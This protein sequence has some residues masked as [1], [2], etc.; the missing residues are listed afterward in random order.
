MTQTIDAPQYAALIDG[1]VQRVGGETRAVV[2]PYTRQQIG[3][4][5]IAPADLVGDAVRSARRAFPAWA[6]LAGHLRAEVL[7]RVAD[8]VLEHQDELARLE[9]AENGKLLRETAGSAAM[10]ARM[11]RYYAG[12]A[13]KLEGRSVPMDSD[14]YLDYT[15]REPVGIVGLILP[16]N[17]PLLLLCNKLAPALAT[18]NCAVL[19]PSEYATVVIVRFAELLLEAGIPPGVVNVVPGDARTGAALTDDPQLDH[20]SFTGGVAT[21]RLISQRAGAMLTP[22]TMELGGKSANI[23]FADADLDRAAA[24][25]VGGIFGAAGQACV[26]G[27]RLLIEHSVLD[28]VLDRVAGRARALVVGDPTDGRTQFGPLANEPNVRRVKACI[29]SAVEAGG[30]QLTC[31]EVNTD[32]YF[33]APTIFTGMDN[34][35]DLAQSEVFGPVLAVIPFRDE[36]DAFRL[37]NDTPYGLAAGAWTSDVG[38]AHRAA[39]QLKAGTVWL[40]TY[41]TSGVQAPFGGQ[42]WSGHGRE[43]GLEGIDQY[44]RTKNVI[45]DITG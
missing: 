30:K 13:D 10:S 17:A 44:L 27:S 21:G 18:G 26:A 8:V 7:H 37:A 5:E 32:S 24:G 42:G 43:R 45:V 29:A 39:R 36:A 1:A 3:S 15:V 2:N 9:T 11:F 34:H 31:G 33:V 38:R 12:L 35:S 4:F 14:R 25:V 28:D 20:L 23:V 41:R 22:T 40:N 6:A 19:K 16:W